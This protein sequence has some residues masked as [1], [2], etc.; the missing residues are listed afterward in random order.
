M[1]EY[2]VEFLFFVN[3]VLMSFG[4]KRIAVPGESVSIYT[5]SN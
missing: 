2:Y 1:H 5:K 3:S 4:A